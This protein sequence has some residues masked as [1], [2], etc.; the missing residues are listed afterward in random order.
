MLKKFAGNR[1]VTILGRQIARHL[2]GDGKLIE[3]LALF[4]E[5]LHSVSFTGLK[6][7]WFGNTLW[8]QF[9]PC[10]GITPS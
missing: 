8:F 10:T 1:R 5:C 2:P 4:E 3:G 9:F 6:M 7:N